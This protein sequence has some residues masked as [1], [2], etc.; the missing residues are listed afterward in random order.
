MFTNI[1]ESND[2]CD[3]DNF[4]FFVTVVFFNRGKFWGQPKEVLRVSR[5]ILKPPWGPWS[6]HDVLNECDIHSGQTVWQIAF[7]SG[8]K[9]NSA[10]WK[11][12]KNKK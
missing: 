1:A 6:P 7:G 8:F 4:W 10:V 12:L 9:C 2:F 5:S 3:F 11:I